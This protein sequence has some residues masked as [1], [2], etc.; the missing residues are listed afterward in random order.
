[1]NPA[2]QSW[3]KRGL[4]KSRYWALN[5]WIPIGRR[6][7]IGRSRYVIAKLLSLNRVEDGGYWTGLI[8]PLVVWILRLGVR[9]LK[10]RREGF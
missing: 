8:G 4:P 9:A 3:F 2:T 1:M 10:I 6:V 7:D 5:T